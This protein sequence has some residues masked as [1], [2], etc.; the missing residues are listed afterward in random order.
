M[1]LI[2]IPI[3]TGGS[4]SIT[5]TVVTRV[6]NGSV[7]FTCIGNKLTSPVFSW[8]FSSGG[9]QQLLSNSDS[10]IN[11]QQLTTLT[12]S[13][14]ILSASRSDAGQYIC[15]V[16]NSLVNTTAVGTLTVYCKP[17]STHCSSSPSYHSLSLLVAPTIYQQLQ[18]QVAIQP[19]TATFTCSANGLPRPTISWLRQVNGQSLTISQSSKYSIV[20]AP[21][22]TQSVTSTLTVANTAIDDAVMYTCNATNQ[23]GSADSTG[24]LT[25]QG[26][27]V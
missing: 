4:I 18:D 27:Y 16:T 13:L 22:G 2:L 3:S 20:T 19:N 24:T 26:M 25:V 5:P 8:Y 17:L 15:R 6:E 1:C 9:I 11:I 10:N 12:S 23:A 21:V 14:S 7:T